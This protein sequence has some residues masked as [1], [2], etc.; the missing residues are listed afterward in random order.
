VRQCH[1]ESEARPTAHVPLAGSSHRH[2]DC[3]GVTVGCS[4]TH[5][6]GVLLPQTAAVIP[7]PHRFPGGPGRTTSLTDFTSLMDDLEERIFGRLDDDTWFYPGHG[8]DS[9][10]GVERLHLGEW[11]ALGW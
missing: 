2:R 8:K 5:A 10:L 6:I 3:T 1:T 4:Q 9:T 11:R 7:G